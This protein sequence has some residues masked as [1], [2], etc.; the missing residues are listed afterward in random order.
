[1]PSHLRTEVAMVLYRDLIGKT[2]FFK[3]KSSQF[4]ASIVVNIHPIKYAKNSYIGTRLV[5]NKKWR[6]K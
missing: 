4:I 5:C 2:P 6:L 1:M 3:D